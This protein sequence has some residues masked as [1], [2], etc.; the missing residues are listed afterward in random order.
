MALYSIQVEKHLLAGLIQNPALITDIESFVTEKAFCVK[1]HD[2]IYSCLRSLALKSEFVDK[3]LLAQK[4][5]NLGISFKDDISI[6][7]YIE[8]ISFAPVTAAATIEAA[9]EL[10]KLKALREIEE[11][12]DAIKKHVHKAVAQTLDKTISEVDAIYGDKLSSFNTEVGY[13]S[14]SDGLLDLV[15]ERGN[16]PMEEIGIPT[17]FQEFNRMYG[18]WRRKNLYIVAARAKAGKSTFL[19]EWISE[20]ARL[21]KIP[22][23]VLD[24]EMSKEETQFRMAAA[25]SGVPL[26]YIETGNWRK[27]KEYVEKIRTALKDVKQNYKVDHYFVGNKKIEEIASI[28]RRWYYKVVGRGNDAV[29]CFDYIKSID[30]LTG[31]QQEYQ[32]MGEKVDMLKKLAEELNI[33]I[34]TAVQSNR[35]GIT[36]NREASDLVDDESQVGIS[37]RITW[38]ASYV[39]ILRRR[40]ADEITL[41]T[42]D[43]GTHK[44]IEAVSRWQGRDAAGHQDLVRRQFPDGKIRW[45]KNFLNF[46]ITNF[47]VEERGSL[48]DCITRQNAQFSVADSNQPTI[49]S[50]TL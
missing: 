40:T 5:Q 7:D 47:R 31:N 48:R 20:T 16:N 39:G 3:V 30:K 15:E 4:I 22:A 23:L 6:F 11:T 41:D 14:L 33:P 35:Q 50:E 42:P 19:N 43:S 34:I 44:L 9:K 17:C 29:V 12:A 28:I 38:Y 10:V 26:W 21:N 18:G 25:K 1:P 45:V 13:S 32:L 49:E 24:T 37:D 36:T 8:G 46:Q 2:V 27:N